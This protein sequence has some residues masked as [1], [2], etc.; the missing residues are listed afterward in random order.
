MKTL[1]IRHRKKTAYRRV[2]PYG[3]F[4]VKKKV[5]EIAY[6]VELTEEEYL[7]VLEKEKRDHGS[8]R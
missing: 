4:D 5:D 2:D 1:K 6:I 7:Y 3:V 8:C